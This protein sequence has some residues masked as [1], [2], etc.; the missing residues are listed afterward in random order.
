MT[1]QQRL[2]IGQRVQVISKDE[3]YYE[4]KG[5]IVD[6]IA[7][8]SAKHDSGNVTDDV[9]IDFDEDQRKL[10]TKPQYTDLTSAHES[11]DEVNLEQVYISPDDLKIVKS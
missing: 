1:D 10:L 5:T 9:V 3:E 11:I 2:T 7:I 6:Y 8:G 4:L